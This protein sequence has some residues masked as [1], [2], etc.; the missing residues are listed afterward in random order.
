MGVV[1]SLVESTPLP[2]MARV[3]QKFDDDHI[4]DIPRAVAEALSQ[5][6]IDCRIKRGASIAVT[7]GSRGISNIVEITKTIVAYLRQKGAKPFVVPAMGSH[8]GATAEGQ[9]QVLHSFGFTEESVGCPIKSSMQ[10]QKIADTE[11]GRPVLIDAFAAAADGIIVVNRVKPHTSFTGPYESGLMKM[12]AI[13]LANQAGAEVCHQEGYGRLAVNIEKYGRVI[14]SKAKILFGVAIVENA[15]D[16]TCDLVALPREE[17]ALKEPDILD[18]AK[19]LMP[20]ILFGRLDVLVVDR[21]GKNI[22]GLGM[23]PHVTGCYATTYVSGT[24][25][26]DKLVVL[27]LTDETHGNGNGAGMADVSTRRLLEKFNFE[28]TYPNALTCTLTQAVRLPMIMDNQKLAIQAAIKTASGFDKT[29]IRM[30][31]LSDTLHLSEI[32]ISEAMLPEAEA[33][34]DITILEEPSPLKFNENGDLF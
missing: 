2:R 7:V 24:P 32:Y 20:R 34:P 21:M 5:P 28:K 26:P 1:N 27:D 30:V 3:R 29:S 19:S 12:M 13:G 11:D 10:V 14:L 17:I 31:R 9:L 22:S 6:K 18:R 25:R 8:G 4:E 15:Y 23:D 33:N 16:Q